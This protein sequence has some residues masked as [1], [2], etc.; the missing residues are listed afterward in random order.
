M[1]LSADSRL[2][3]TY[4]K[5]CKM[6]TNTYTSQLASSLLPRQAY[7]SIRPNEDLQDPET[8]NKRLHAINNQV[9]DLT[10]AFTRVSNME[11]AFIEEFF[12]NASNP[13]YERKF[14]YQAVSTHVYDDFFFNDAGIS[15]IPLGRYV[16]YSCSDAGS[17]D[18]AKNFVLLFDEEGLLVSQDK[19]KIRYS[20]DGL[21]IFHK[22]YNDDGSRAI[23]EFNHTV[24]VVILKRYVI[25]KSP[26]VREIVS[27]GSMT[28]NPVVVFQNASRHLGDIVFTPYIKLFYREPLWKEFKIMQPDNFTST[29]NDNHDLRVA[30]TGMFP[31][32]TQILVG[33]SLESAYAKFSYEIDGDFIDRPT[34]TVHESQGVSMVLTEINNRYTT[35]PLVAIIGNQRF[36]VPVSKASELFVFFDGYKLTANIDYTLE[37]NDNI[38]LTLKLY[39]GLPTGKHDVLFFV[40]PSFDEIGT[41]L[42]PNFPANGVVNLKEY[43][44]SR[45]VGNSSMCFSKNR[46]ISSSKISQIVDGDIHVCLD[47]L[48]QFEFNVFTPLDPSLRAYMHDIEGK[49]TCVEEALSYLPMERSAYVQAWLDQHGCGI[50][51]DDG[52][53]KSYAEII[54]ETLNG[55]AGTSGYYTVNEIN[56]FINAVE[57]YIRPELLTIV[58]ANDLYLTQTINIQDNV[59]L[60]GEEDSLPT[61]FIFTCSDTTS[62]VPVSINIIGKTILNENETIPYTFKAIMSNGSQQTIA[63][64]EFT[65]DSAFGVIADNKFTVTADVDITVNSVLRAKATIGGVQITGA[66]SIVIL[67]TNASGIP[68]SLKTTDATFNTA[69][70]TAYEGD[71]IELRY[72]VTYT[73]GATQL[74]V[75]TTI[76][77]SNPLIASVLPNGNIQLGT[78]ITSHQLLSITAKFANA[79]VVVEA[80]PL[81]I[82][83]FDRDAT[84]DGYTAVQ[85]NEFK[86]AVM[87]YIKP[88]EITIIDGNDSGMT[89]LTYQSG[90]DIY[91]DANVENVLPENEFTMDS[92]SDYDNVLLG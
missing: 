3:V 9:T 46:F 68:L 27:I 86:I 56:N 32:D 76:I 48:G 41:K 52:S 35:I 31:P 57:N 81:H 55:P 22:I 72:T 25:P 89:Q 20:Q 79:N 63:V 59:I 30:V 23:P 92:D 75:P 44:L 82:S 40:N 53:V 21:S 12:R 29:L 42:I 28:S 85:T 39:G 11:P 1:M 6:T 74:V 73:N 67:D 51:I 61:D 38:G 2:L 84:V 65:C 69:G 19:Y 5:D 90:V 54:S 36:P 4:V 8:Y 70:I 17:I 80:P 45:W 64:D 91:L 60:D 83:V 13:L 14:V 43:G 26:V 18:L 66:L 24:N 34:Y 71:I 78:N 10:R 16:L 47:R 50:V 87:N 33:N 49:Q 62:V 7:G 37:F 58:D 77:V 15:D 88:L